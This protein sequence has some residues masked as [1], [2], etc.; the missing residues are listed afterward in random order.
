MG[1]NVVVLDAPALGG[2]ARVEEI[3]KAMKI[4]QLV[5]NAPVERFGLCVLRWF[6][7][8]AELQHDVLLCAPLQHGAAGKLAA[9]NR[10]ASLPPG[11]APCRLLPT[12]G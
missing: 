10:S 6:A 5:A 8:I 1:S 4:E 7:R 2:E 3:C 11:R 12:P 9:A